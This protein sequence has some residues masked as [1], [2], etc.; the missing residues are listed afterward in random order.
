[1]KQISGPTKKAAAETAIKDIRR[2]APSILGGRMPGSR[3]GHVDLEGADGMGQTASAI[4]CEN[5]G[6]LASGHGREFTS[7]A[8]LAW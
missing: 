3:R 5:L 7:N 8:M 2:A 6:K 1:M 4:E